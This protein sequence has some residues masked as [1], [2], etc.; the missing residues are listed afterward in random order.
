M[1]FLFDAFVA[2][3]LVFLAVIGAMFLAV[4]LWDRFRGRGD[5]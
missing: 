3:V 5:E 4:L 2:A 1:T